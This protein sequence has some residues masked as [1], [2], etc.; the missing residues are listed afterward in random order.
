MVRRALAMA[1]VGCWVAAGVGCGAGGG[2]KPNPDLAIPETSVPKDV[3]PKG[4][5]AGPGVGGK[6]DAPSSIKPGDAGK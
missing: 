6:K 4:R 5:S 1:V 2:D 3:V